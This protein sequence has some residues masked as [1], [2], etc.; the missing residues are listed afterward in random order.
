MQ[1]KGDPE[2]LGPE[3]PRR[4]PTV[5]GG[6]TLPPDAKG[7][8][9]LR[10]G[11]LD[12][13]REEPAHGPRDGEPHLAVSLRQ[14]DRADAERLR[15]AGP[16]ADAP[17]VARLARGGVRRA[18]VVGEGD[19][20]AH[21]AVADVSAGEPRRRRR[22]R[23][24]TSRTTTCGGSTGAARRRVDPRHA[25]RGGRQ[26]R[27]HARRRAPVP[28]HEHLELHA[29]QPVQ[30]RLRDEQAQ[31][32]PD[33]AAVPAASVPRRSST[34]PTRTRAPTAASPARRRCRRCS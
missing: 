7:S 9:R 20:P 29:A 27:P 8:G 28:R 18:R 10:T 31:R 4:F 14:G 25:A 16:A 19:A 32:L 3:V 2:R 5:L 1:I 12:R 23:R 17:G 26:P 22:T 21:H 6:Q 34:A 11:G 33:A 13:R 15:H 24:S 30:G